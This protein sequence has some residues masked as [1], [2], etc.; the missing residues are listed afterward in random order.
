[1]DISLPLDKMTSL[2]KIAVMEKLWD[3]LCRDPETIL[4]PEWHKE[5]LE[6][7]ENQINEGKAKFLA[8]DE[9]KE[10]IRSQTK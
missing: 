8:F 3:D 9:A 6:A 10:R 7:R 5:T 1:M 4:S 2:D